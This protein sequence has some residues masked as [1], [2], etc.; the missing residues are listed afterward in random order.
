MMV[1]TYEALSDNAFN[2]K[3]KECAVEGPVKQCN[4]FTVFPTE[5]GAQLIGPN[6]LAQ[7]YV[8]LSLTGDELQSTIAH[9]HVHVL[10]YLVGAEALE[11]VAYLMEEVLHQAVSR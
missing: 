8:R 10:Q 2:R 3:F 5:E 6:K 11:S 7:V 9:E 1:V 4:G